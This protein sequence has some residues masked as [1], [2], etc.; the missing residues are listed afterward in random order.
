MQVSATLMQAGV[1][2]DLNAALEQAERRAALRGAFAL[3][4][5]A[6]QTEGFERVSDNTIEW[7][8]GSCRAVN[9][10]PRVWPE[11][12]RIECKNEDT[13]PAL[14]AEFLVSGEPWQSRG[15]ELN[16]VWSKRLRV[17]ASCEDQ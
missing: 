8:A 17:S 7:E 1:T 16:R 9:P 14:P 13:W 6:A 2:G 3:T 15:E 5:C 4:F 10:S 11:L 12:L